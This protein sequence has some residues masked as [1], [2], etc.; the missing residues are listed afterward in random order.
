MT[1]QPLRLPPIWVVGVLVLGVVLSLALF[2]ML[3][4]WEQRELEDQAAGLVRKQVEKL[5]I[6]MLRS[7][8]V[9]YSVSSLY[10]AEGKVEPEQFKQFMAGALR[11]QPEL[12]A[13]SWNPLITEE[14]R[15][16]AEAKMAAH[17]PDF[18]F[19]EFDANGK[20]VVA[21]RREHYV[22]VYFIEP[23]DRNRA[24]LGF[25]L[26]SQPERRKSLEKARDTGMPVTTGP[27]RLA[28]EKAD[29]TGF[30][31][32]LPIYRDKDKTPNTV[33]E[34]RAQ[35]VG[36]ADAAYR[37]ADLVGGAFKELQEQ[38][39]AARLL[40]ESP[41]GTLLY[42]TADEV[43]SNSGHMSA[44]S[45]LKVPGRRWAV[46]FAPTEEFLTAHVQYQS[47]LALSAG[48]AFT[49]LATAY[50][51]GG[52]HRTRE[53]ALANVAMAEEVKVRQQAEAMAASANQAKSDFLA[54]MSHEIRTPLNAILG[55]TQL[56][57][58]DGHLRAE[59]KDSINGISASG[60]HLL[61][62]INEILDLSKIEAGRME[63]SPVDF[64]LVV[65]GQRLAATFQPL[66]AQKRIGFRLEMDATGP[67]RVRGDEGKLRQV[68]INL[69]G[70]AVKFTC[71]GEVY[72]H[73]KSKD[74]KT[75]LFEVIDT[76]LGIPAE[77]QSDVFKPF[78]QGSGARHQGGT[79]L[80]LAIA[81]R[82][83]ELLGGRLEL[84]SERG[85]GSRFF[86]EIPL[87]PATTASESPREVIRLAEGFRVCAL[88]V[89][90]RQE[91]CEVMGGLLAMI[92]CEVL[93]ATSGE[94]AV[95]IVKEQKPDIVFLDLILPGLNGADTARQIIAESGW[96][97]VV[98]HTAS[99][100]AKHRDEALAV[101]CVDFLPKPVHCDKMFECLKR[102]LGVEF[103]YASPLPEN[104]STGWQ[105]ERV[106]L[107]DELYSRLTVAAELHSTTALKAGLQ[108]LRQLGPDAQ[109]LAEN[110]RHLMRSYDMDG[111]L[112]LLV[113]AAAPA[114]TNQNPTDYG[115][116]SQ[117]SNRA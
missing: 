75:W 79:G 16:S 22:P 34:R 66:C 59:Q 23:V 81:R 26:N 2:K 44:Q 97:K 71:S 104:T 7:I 92:G 33:E 72:L 18:A 19:R 30:L 90:D 47:W 57:L 89:D 3:R 49:L 62:L 13:L 115:L 84:Q 93:Y 17:F 88:V 65:L 43:K 77:E 83:V 58:R 45:W 36:F 102:H 106:T 108:D 61:G 70:N 6:S 46:V 15:S 37:V 85:I 35:L 100:L 27:I 95:E 8:E 32:L 111:I 39:I 29:Q 41:T 74:Q 31:V 98:A 60:H 86:F 54:S 107:P 113:R 21:Q 51:Y 96:T 10:E 5:E 105:G 53:A 28:Q 109:K 69:L 116:Q 25:D 64:D 76:G 82:Q 67:M 78:H 99:A 11:R 38:G 68:L 48:L 52:W 14:Q 94:E 24:A 87:D 63:L 112:R 55:Y 9:L 114:I 1:N 40:D 101:G 50:L 73:L 20:L 91:N 42:H 110:I 80:G 103:E 4:G 56:M 117:Q 12:Q